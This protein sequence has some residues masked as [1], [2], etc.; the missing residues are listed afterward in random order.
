MDLAVDS[1]I[2]MAAG[3]SSS[4][5]LV[6][7]V[8]EAAVALNGLD[9]APR[10]FVNFCGEGEWFVGTRGGSAD[11]AAMKFGSRGMVSHVKFYEFELIERVRFPAA[12]RMVLCNSFVQAKKAAGARAAFNARVV[13][14]LLGLALVR[15]AFP[16]LVPLVR[17]VRDLRPETLGVPTERV[18]EVLLEMPESISADEA[19]RAFRDDPEAWPSLA[20]HL[21]GT[22][23]QGEYPVRGVMLY[24]I[25]ECAR[26]REAA[27][28]LKRGDMEAFGALMNTSHDGERRFRVAD[29][30]SAEVY[31]PDVSDGYLRG[32]IA[33]LQ[34][35]DRARAE[36]A[37]LSN[38]PGA[39][40]CSTREV[41]ALVDIA[42]RTPGVLGAQIAGAGLGGCAMAL[43]EGKAVPE[44]R[45]RLE[46]LFYGRQGL[47]S[48]VYVCTPAAGSRVV[49]VE[50]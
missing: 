11:H 20:A 28:C 4:S 33:D 19:R 39:Y 31:T 12:H 24:G 29:D 38:Q 36:R 45:A 35:G 37:R 47:P 46:E 9:L 7:A 2:P 44:L 22:D 18:Y 15:R 25:A 23:A 50:S 16:A 1:D 6:V 27:A 14:Y 17:L 30:L 40:R 3:M 26:A 8:A 13:S 10:Q 34:S 41:D 49:A 21:G 43:V 42:L 32:R 48:G 5:A